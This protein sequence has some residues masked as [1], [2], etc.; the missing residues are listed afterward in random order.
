[1]SEDPFRDFTAW[2]RTLERLEQLTREGELDGCQDALLDMMRS[3]NWR[4]REAALEAARRV[5]EPS[6]DLVSQVCGIMANEGLYYQVRVLA[7]E[8]LG[9]CLERLRDQAGVRRE[10]RAQMHELLAGIDVPVVHR[11]VR[12]ILP[13]VE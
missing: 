9:V 12:R 4:L 3:Q 1:M 13:T 2:G 7:A 10:I 8:T 11:A 6:Q 5:R